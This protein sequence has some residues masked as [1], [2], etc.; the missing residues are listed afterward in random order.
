MAQIKPLTDDQ[1][2]A[3]ADERYRAIRA[4]V[5]LLAAREKEISLE[6][7]KA[8]AA[9][10]DRTMDGAVVDILAGKSPEDVP[11]GLTTLSLEREKIKRQMKAYGLARM[12]QKETLRVIREARSLDAGEALRKGH[13]EIVGRLIKAVAALIE[14]ADEEKAYRDRLPAA[15]YDNVLPDML[16]TANVLGLA[17]AHPLARY[18]VGAWR[19]RAK[20]YCG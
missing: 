12:Q 2:Y 1:E 13:Q 10:L 5:A 6:L 18:E 3:K 20:A 19:D 4:T 8:V 9:R 7:S 11:E 17:V 14:I 15:G 16:P